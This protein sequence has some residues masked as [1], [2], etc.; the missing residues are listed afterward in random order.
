MEQPYTPNQTPEQ[1]KETLK[2]LP[3]EPGVY[4]YFDEKETVIYVGK[5]KD[6]KKRVSSYFTQKHEKGKTR[7]LVSK[8]T[9]IEYTVV[10]TEQDAFLLENV[11]IKKLQP[12]YNIQLKDDK[13]YPYICIVNEPFPRVLLTRKVINNGSQYYGPYTSISRVRTLIELIKSLFPLRTCSFSLTQKNIENERFKPCLEFHLGNC[14][15][16]C[17]AKQAT[18]EYTKNIDQIKHILKGNIQ[19]VVQHLKNQMADFAE[20]YEFEKAE[21]LKYKWLQLQDYQA[22]STIVNPSITN[23]DVFFI[24]YDPNPDTDK[25]AY[26]SYLKI[27][28]GAIIHSKIIELAKKLDETPEEL[29]VFGIQ[30]LIQTFGSNSTEFILP[31]TVHYPNENIKITVPQRGDKKQLLELAEKNALYYQKQ[32]AMKAALHKKPEERKFEVLNEL[33]KALRLTEIPLHI[34]CFDNSNIQGAHPVASL[35]VFKNAN[36]AKKDYRH[37]NI[38]T[39][40]GPND[41]AS[42]EEVVY[43]RYKRLIE[44]DQPLPQLILIDGGKGQLS[45]ALASLQKLELIG[46]IAIAGIAKKL[47]EIYLPNDPIPLHIDKRSDA[48]KLIQ[49]IRNEAHRFAIT[50]HRQKRSKNTFVS[51]LQTIKGIGDSSMEKLLTHFKSIETIQNASIETLKEVVDTRKAGIIFNYFSQ[52]KMNT[53]N[54]AK[55]EKPPVIE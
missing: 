44:E 45:S 30:E 2:T 14:K 12:R 8:I 39:V 21:K 25:K 24:A 47:E 48:L 36:P 4:Q 9:R 34:E 23:T 33:K 27:V 46:K 16:P 35:V 20:K 11:L 49:H 51:E 31:F 13:T 3:N 1:L 38:K 6:L 54:A 29:L 52:K 19:I 22:K 15:A 26:V 41:F 53:T 43:R 18:E 37:F 50:F 28:N 40:V 10:E 32:V 42:M 55:Q 17:I 7:I 5:A